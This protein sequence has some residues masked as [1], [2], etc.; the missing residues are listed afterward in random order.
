[1]SNSYIGDVI[2]E[3]NYN[4]NFNFN[5][6][7][8][9]NP[10]SKKNADA[11]RKYSIMIRDHI[12][13]VINVWFRDTGIETLE[14]IDYGDYEYEDPNHPYVHESPRSLRTIA[15][16]EF[17]V[18]KKIIADIDDIIRLHDR[19]RYSADEF[20]AAANYFFSTTDRD[21]AKYAI[22]ELK[23]YQRNAH[24]FT[25][26][27]YHRETG[28]TSTDSDD[29]IIYNAVVLDMPEVYIWE[30]IA[31]W[32]ANFGE[33]TYKYNTNLGQNPFQYYWGRDTYYIWVWV[34]T[35]TGGYWSKVWGGPPVLPDYVELSPRTNNRI[36]RIVDRWAQVLPDPEEED[37]GE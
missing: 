24:E 20:Y 31:V 19:S 34:P 25:H 16:E 37:D 18:D 3:L 1:M 6:Q 9:P 32:L 5:K 13:D 30:R 22:S 4:A 35:M 29:N 7:E 2:N 28:P 27:M 10:S 11:N 14:G 17:Q 12:K 33:A 26:Y 21:A 36:K 15:I 8:L 23:H